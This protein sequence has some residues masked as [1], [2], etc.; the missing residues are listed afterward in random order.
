MSTTKP[1]GVVVRASDSWSRD[2]KFGS[3]P[4]H[5]RVAQDNLGF[6]PS[7]VGESST[8]LLAGV[9]VGRIHLCRV[10]GNSVWSHMADD[11]P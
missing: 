6:H 10:A 3:W 9:K 5:C 7:G 11:V 2:R 4:V 1:G 8:S